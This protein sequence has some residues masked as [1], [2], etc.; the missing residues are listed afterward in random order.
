MS[1]MHVDRS[2]ERSQSVAIDFQKISTKVSGQS[3]FNY[4]TKY[5]DIYCGDG[6][7]LFNGTNLNNPT[8][9]VLISLFCPK[10]ETKYSKVTWV[11]I[12]SG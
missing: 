2:V 9:H 3:I 6:I 12:E 4:L 7:C 5:R 10:T 11:C 8:L 1:A